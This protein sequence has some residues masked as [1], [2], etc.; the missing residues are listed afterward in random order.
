MDRSDPTRRR[1]LR[2]T[3]TATTLAVTG[4]AGCL[5]SLAPPGTPAPAEPT[6]AWQQTLDRDRTTS[7][8]AIDLTDSG[9]VVAETVG[10][11][12]DLTDWTGVLTVAD[13]TGTEFVHTAEGRLGHVATDVVSTD[14]GFVYAGVRLDAEGRATDAW[15]TAVT[16][17]GTERWRTRLDATGVWLCSPGDDDTVR[18]L[19]QSRDESSLRFG[20]LLPDDGH[21][22]WLWT[23]DG[24][25]VVSDVLAVADRV[26]VGGGTEN[27]SGIAVVSERSADGRRR[28][29]RYAEES[30]PYPR[31]V[32]ADDAPAETIAL[33]GTSGTFTAGFRLLGLGAGTVAAAEIDWR[34]TATGWRVSAILDPSAWPTLGRHRL[35]VAHH[36]VERDA[37]DTGAQVFAVDDAGRVRWR[38]NLLRAGDGDDRWR[39]REAV[40]ADRGLVVAGEVPTAGAGPDLGVARL[41]PRET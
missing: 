26:L 41:E 32:F 4:L 27:E 16:L 24:P 5:D 21:V 10:T 35:V 15:V 34:L 29:R 23:A 6:V 30:V 7:V 9:V 37:D 2:Q 18:L 38:A 20:R 36:A 8:N 40:S 33:N 1:L 22:E 12:D 3:G 28:L 31:V 19:V 17:D 25:P 13:A 11:G 39:L 14:T